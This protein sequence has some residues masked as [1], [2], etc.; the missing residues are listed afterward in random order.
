MEQREQDRRSGMTTPPIKVNLN[1]AKTVSA[2]GK[3]IKI[4]EEN[5]MNFH[6]LGICCS[7]LI[8]T[9]KHEKTQKVDI[10]GFTVI[11]QTLESTALRK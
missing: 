3:V 11:K 10:L 9:Q 4:L 1:W 7:S 2:R 6:D 5:G 8:I